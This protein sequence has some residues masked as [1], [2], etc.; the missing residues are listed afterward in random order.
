NGR[1]YV[2]EATD[3]PVAVEEPFAPPINSYKPW[4]SFY[5][6]QADGTA[7]DYWSYVA[8][9]LAYGLARLLKPKRQI[10]EAAQRITAGITSDEARL[11]RLYD[12]CRTEIKNLSSDTSGY[13]PEQIEALKP[14]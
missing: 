11:Q 2:Y 4:F 1:V 7:K 10:K 14:N 6:T 9:D 12:Y 8:G 5:L 3:I 13:T